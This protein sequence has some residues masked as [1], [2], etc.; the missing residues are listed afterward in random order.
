MMI[1]KKM[2]RIVLEGNSVE[3]V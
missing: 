3:Y 2:K 1:F